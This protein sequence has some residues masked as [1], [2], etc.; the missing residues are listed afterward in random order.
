VRDVL[1]EI[2]MKVLL[3]Q[4]TTFLKCPNVVFSPVPR[5]NDRGYLRVAVTPTTFRKKITLLSFVHDLASASMSNIPLHREKRAW[6]SS[7]SDQRQRGRSIA[8]GSEICKGFHKAAYST[9]FSRQVQ[10]FGKNLLLMPSNR[11]GRAKQ[12]KTSSGMSGIKHSMPLHYSQ[13]ESRCE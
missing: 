8:H 1:I 6:L 10:C 3:T 13:V 2:Y 7:L 12:I 9:N 11:E 4:G 5:Q